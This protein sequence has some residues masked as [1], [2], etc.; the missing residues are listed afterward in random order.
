MTWIR[1]QISWP[2]VKEIN[3]FPKR[4]N[5]VELW[6][7]IYGLSEQ[8]VEQAVVFPVVRGFDLYGLNSSL[9]CFQSLLLMFCSPGPEL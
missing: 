3:K 4:A 5:H 7:F 6:R 1:Y 2:P 8:A 9:K